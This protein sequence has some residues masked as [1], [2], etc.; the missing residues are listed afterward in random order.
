MNGKGKI[1]C[2]GKSAQDLNTNVNP[3]ISFVVKLSHRD[4]N[5]PIF[6]GSFLA[7]HHSGARGWSHRPGEKSYT[8]HHKLK[9]L[10]IYTSSL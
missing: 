6:K 4:T 1:V 10:N 8:T 7:L 5:K 9:F 3:N 2:G